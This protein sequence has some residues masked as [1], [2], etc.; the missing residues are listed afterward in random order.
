MSLPDR[1]RSLAA[2]SV[3]HPASPNTIRQR[4]MA[5]YQLFFQFEEV[6]EATLRY[7]NWAELRA[8]T[9]GYKDIDRAIADL[10]RP[11]ALTASLNLYRANLAPRMPGPP[12]EFPPVTAPTMGVWSDGDRYL[13]G[14][15]MRASG[16]LVKGPWR[17]EEIAGASH[18]IPLDAPEELGALLVDWLSSW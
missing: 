9:P 4:E 3:P 12:R 1:V 14:A 8:L 5:W 18:W 6:A 11:G 2:L 7:E 16:D 15:R 17:Y 13:D 10:S